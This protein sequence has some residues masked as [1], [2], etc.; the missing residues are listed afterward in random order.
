MAVDLGATL[1]RAAPSEPASVAQLADDV[2]ACL[3]SV[4]APDALAPKDR[5]QLKRWAVELFQWCKRHEDAALPPLTLAQLRAGAADLLS[6]SLAALPEPLPSDDYALQVRLHM[7]AARSL[8]EAKA[9]ASERHFARATELWRRGA[10][11][12]PDFAARFGDLGFAL[13][14]WRAEASWTAGGPAALENSRAASEVLLATPSLASE[15]LAFA[16]ALFNRGVQLHNRGEFRDALA[17]LALSTAVLE[18]PGWADAENADAAV[19]ATKIARNHRVSALAQLELQQV[20][21]ALAACEQA[22]RAQ[23]SAEVLALRARALLLLERVAEAEEAFAAAVRHADCRPDVAMALCGL[24]A[25]HAPEAACEAAYQLV[26]ARFPALDLVVVN[27]LASQLE[28][29]RFGA[30]AQTAH[31][32]AAAHVSGQRPLRDGSLSHVLQLM[33]SAAQSCFD[34]KELAQALEWLRRQEALLTP[35]DAANRANCLRAQALVHFELGA[36]DLAQRAAAQA[37]AEAPADA[38]AALLHV[39]ALLRLGDARASDEFLALARMPEC[40]GE[41]VGL[42]A[43]DAIQAGAVDFAA[44]ALEKLLDFERSNKGAGVGA[45]PVLRSL[46]SLGVSKLRALSKSASAP[47]RGEGEGAA[48]AKA[49]AAREG[50]AE[51]LAL[52]SAAAKLASLAELGAELCRTRVGQDADALDH[53]RWLAATLFNTAKQLGEVAPRCAAVRRLFLSAAALFETDTAADTAHSQRL[54]LLLAASAALEVCDAEAAREALAALAR[55]DAVNR[56]AAASSDGKAMTP[57]VLLLTFRA[58]LCA[59]HDDVAQFVEGLGLQVGG[60]AVE[61][62]EAAAALSM[63]PPVERP[64]L[65]LIAVRHALRLHLAAPAETANARKVA[66]LLRVSV[67]LGLP[68]TSG[69]PVYREVLQLAAT[70]RDTLGRDYPVEEAQWLVA[71]AWNEGV[72]L[73]YSDNLRGAEQLMACALQLHTLLLGAQFKVK[74]DQ[75]KESYARVLE[76]LQLEAAK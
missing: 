23:P 50:D 9:A 74:L 8:S 68:K 47:P 49:E 16:M 60:D 69:L 4:A 48:D 14:S 20:P 45:L 33:W 66:E 44:A 26:E 35:S 56:R 6:L 58:K 37:C 40:S 71:Q 52:E 19:R 28:L 59:G 11:A 53:A 12:K 10:A 62:L 70:R 72:A 67:A 51:R 15:R 75:L 7:R 3:A 54:S 22:L 63:E 17:W 34:R 2:K 39:R 76:R 18:A 25:K 36:V 29:G 24:V 46:V 38:T 32:I 30:A 41:M 42:L 27:K 65:A 61:I 57:L 55:L 1:L 64:D 21:Q 31:A 73:Y 43:N 13:F 5:R